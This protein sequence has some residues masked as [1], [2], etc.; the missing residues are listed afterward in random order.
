MILIELFYLRLLK[1]DDNDNNTQ[2]IITSPAWGKGD[3]PCL[4]VSLK[5]GH[6]YARVIGYGKIVTIYTKQ[7]SKSVLKGV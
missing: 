2:E 7:P 5:K 6:W 4:E 3:G 1:V